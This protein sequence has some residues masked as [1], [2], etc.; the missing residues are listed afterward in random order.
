MKTEIYP[1]PL[2][3]DLAKVVRK[4]AKATGLSLA[5][6]MRQGLRRGIPTLTENL[7]PDGRRGPLTEEECRQCWGVPNDEF[8]A[9]NHHC[10]SLPAPKPDFS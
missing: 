2:P 10:A 7:S 6:T 8:D 9:L 5:E 3:P 4:A 1:L